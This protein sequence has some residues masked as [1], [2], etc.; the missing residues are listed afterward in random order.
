MLFGISSAPE[1]FQ[2]RLD[3]TLEGLHGIE[4]IADDIVIFGS[5]D[6]DE[7]AE[8]SHD[9][10][11]LSLLERC[12]EKGLKLNEKKLKFKMKT[13]SYMGHVLSAQGLAADPEK[14]NAITEMPRPTNV[15]GIQR[16]LGV[17]NYLAKFTPQLSTVSA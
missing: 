13:A 12:R 2:R 3:E 4:V 9:E 1:E 7:E 8:K 11:F 5:G 16:L 6:T 17:A 14:V 10:A 15:Q